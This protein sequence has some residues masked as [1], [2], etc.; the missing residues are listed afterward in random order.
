MP[1][2]NP[3]TG[4]SKWVLAHDWQ[5][6]YEYHSSRSSTRRMK[7]L[8]QITF[9]TFTS[10]GQCD[11][12]TQIPMVLL[13]TSNQKPD[14]LPYGFAVGKLNYD[15]L[16]SDYRAPLD[17]GA[18]ATDPVTLMSECSLIFLSSSMLV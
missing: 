7:R 6:S 12:K 17:K 13:N 14:D 5:V 3:V 1:D 8:G 4:N 18:G 9:C 15:E 11:G 2:Y 10:K 16:Q